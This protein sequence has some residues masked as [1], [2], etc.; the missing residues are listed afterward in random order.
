MQ[1][2]IVLFGKLAECLDLL[3]LLPHGQHDQ[4]HLFLL[5]APLLANSGCPLL[6]FDSTDEFLLQIAVAALKDGDPSLK[7]LNIGCL[8]L[9]F[10]PQ[11]TH[12]PLQRDVSCIKF[13]YPVF[14]CHLVLALN[15]LYDLSWLL[16]LLASLQLIQL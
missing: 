3:Q 10:L 1:L 14:Q 6:C 2:T 7:V 5:L 4:P 12:R 9:T 8:L 11:H 16:H 13:L 15:I